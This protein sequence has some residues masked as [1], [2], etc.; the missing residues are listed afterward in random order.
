MR[1]ILISDGAN[2]GHSGGKPRGELTKVVLFLHGNAPPQR[3]LETQKKLACLGFQLLDRPPYSS[4]LA[5]SDY[6]LF[7]G[8]NKM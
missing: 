5:P 6:H 1:S 3:T 7:P 4:D 2:E 8:L